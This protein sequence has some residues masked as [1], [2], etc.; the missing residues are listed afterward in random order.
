MMFTP[1]Q[2][3]P[4]NPSLI[5]TTNAIAIP[6]SWETLSAQRVRLRALASAALTL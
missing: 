5:A 2:W 1:I 4:P 6:P 3:A